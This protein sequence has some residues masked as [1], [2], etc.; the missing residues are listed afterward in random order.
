[1]EVNAMGATISRVY[2]ASPDDVF[3][4]A[5]LAPA[6]LGYDLLRVDALRRTLSFVTTTTASDQREVTVSVD[7]DGSQSHVVVTESDPIIP[8][9]ARG[10]LEWTVSV[11][12]RFLKAVTEILRRPSAGWLADPS[13]RFAERWWDGCAWTNH[14]RDTERGPQYQDQPGNFAAPMLLDAAQA[15]R[16]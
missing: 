7:G 5:Q 16:S 12:N 9:G 4:A 15:A 11:P 10:R 13:G 2:S 14:A 8:L 3:E 1:V 6:S